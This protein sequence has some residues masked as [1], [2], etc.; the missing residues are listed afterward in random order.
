MPD[1]DFETPMMLQYMAI[2]KQYPDCV[3]FFRMGDF[4]EMF[5][6][7]AKLG[8][9]VLD[10][11]LTSRS[12]GKDGR[13]PMA[14]VPY[15]AVDS[16]LQKMVKAGYKVAICEQLTPPNSR[17]LV[18]R[19][20]IRIVT[21]GTVLDEQALE[22]KRNNFIVTVAWGKDALGLA[23][24]DISTGLFQAAELQGKDLRSLLLDELTR[25]APA[26]CVLSEERYN[27]GVTLSV[28]KNQPGM[29]VFPYEGWDRFAGNAER[30]LKD[31][32]HIQSLAVFDLEESPLAV[33]AAAPLLGYLIETQ[34]GHISHIRK[35]TPYR[36]EDTMQLDRSTITNLELFTTLREGE[37]RGSLLNT[38]DMTVTPMG[39][40]LLRR[41]L[42]KPLVSK[43]RIVARHDLVE[44]FV[45]QRHLR[46]ELRQGMGE[47]NDVERIV[48]RLATNQANA[49]DLVGMKQSLRILVEVGKRI[50]ALSPTLAG[51]LAKGV[52]PDIPQLADFIENYILEN[53]A[54]DP[55]NGGIVAEGINAELDS[56]RRT[57]QGA[58]DWLVD[59]EVRERQRTG[60][61]SLK[62]R[63][64]KVFGFYIEV[65]KSNLRQVPSDYDRKQTLVN[66]E[67]F[68]TPELKR[69]EE[70]ILTAE[71]RM[72]ALEYE[73]FLE[74]VAKVLSYTDQ[75]QAAA[76]VV[77]EID[78][79]SGFAELAELLHYSRPDVVNSQRM[80]IQG[81]WH[82]VVEQ[83]LTDHRFVPNDT[84]LDPTERQLILI[85]GPNMAG[86]SVYIRQVAVIALL[87]QIG[88]FV[89]AEQAKLPVFDRIFVRSGA[90]DMIS[91]GM[92]TFMVEMVETAQIL[93]NA[94][95]KSLIVMDEIGRGT[96]TFDGISIA[97][98]VAEYLVTNRAVAANTLFATHYHELQELAN[99]FPTKIGNM[100][101]AV[102]EERGKPV[103]LHTLVEGGAS[104]SFGIAVSRLAGVPD[105][106]NERAEELLAEL[107]KRNVEDVV[108]YKN[109]SQ[110]PGKKK[111]KIILSRIRN[112]DINTT[113]PLQAIELLVELQQQA[114]EDE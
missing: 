84:L 16:Y 70:I 102:E 18:E 66:G 105:A 42:M 27:D 36:A 112:V 114:R 108:N 56:L 51:E 99:R 64:N 45:R 67:R 72:N 5:L 86:K 85:T 82:P 113:T 68:T 23:I 63:F 111:A 106:V 59:L 71:E 90:S 83:L 12:K 80:H 94:T 54:F 30:Y 3:L 109:A 46:A 22:R 101:M 57:V 65:S 77:A 31:T 58:K 8:A 9:Q 24:A 13:I 11:T 7:D 38:I 6:D 20:V 96:S 97:W 107:E 35:I 75:I 21:P 100:H 14:G 19:D 91:A 78:C 61:G 89:P 10:I 29:N 74:V 88:S 62:V 25:L 37:Q 92:S 52:S 73:I 104:H 98:A 32:F 2:K 4:Y 103:F 76:Q 69:Q 41:W 81:G 48:A 28:L 15:H 79:L 26:E 44:E 53:P 110:E 47:S 34:K 43:K 17:G 1:H 55:K 39:G 33:K 40:R 60:I 87:N 93:H 50:E 49:K 95:E